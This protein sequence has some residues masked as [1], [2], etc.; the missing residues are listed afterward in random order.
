MPPSTS[1]G[2][3][4]TIIAVG[5]TV[6][7]A[8]IASRLPAHPIGW[9]CCAIGVLA[10]VQHFSGEYAIYALRAPPR[11]APGGDAML[12]VSLWAWILA[13]GLIE[14]LL[15]LFPNGRLPSKRWRPLAWLSAALTLMAAILISI[16]PD[17]A[18]DALG[19]S[20]N[21]HISI[22]NPLGVEGLPNLYR[23]V[24]TLVLALGLAAAAS[25]V[26]GSAREE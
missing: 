6:I 17:A 4:L 25:V 15:L 9:I 24:Q 11:G 3:N 19:S 12:W 13:F 22:P 5:Y 23:P 18:L 14:F 10:A 8:I 2:L 7:G 20:D 21:V 1:T 16:S 26:I